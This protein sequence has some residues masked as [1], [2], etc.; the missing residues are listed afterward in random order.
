M[1]RRARM[2]TALT[3][4]LVLAAGCASSPPARMHRALDASME[5]VL[6]TESYLRSVAGISS[7][8]ARLTRGDG[9]I[10]LSDVAPILRYLAE[11]RD[12][13]R[14]RALRGFATDR[15]VRRGAAGY[16]L[17]RRYREGDAFENATPYGYL[18][19][20]Q[21]LAEGWRLLGD[22]AS[23]SVLAQMAPTA[24][25]AGQNP[26]LMYQLSVQCGD[27]S[28]VVRTDPAAARAVLARAKKFIGTQR[29]AEEQ[30]ALGSTAVDGEV[31]LLSC[32]TRLGLALEDPDSAVW[33]LDHLL[34][35]LEPML[36]HSGRPDAGTAADIL[37]TLRRVREAGPA[38]SRHP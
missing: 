7:Q 15:M 6:R 35:H 2:A 36:V 1:S 11:V 33:Y 16:E 38:Y 22:T 8:P 17:A 20:T 3:G 5:R 13:T 32:L 21:A 19:T 28:E 23:A 4:L 37:L 27:A 29:A 26:S 25:G 9:F 34:D 10:Y 24:V 18:W 14:F 30:A 12:T 31:D